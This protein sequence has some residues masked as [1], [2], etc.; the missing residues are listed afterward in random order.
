MTIISAKAKKKK[1][2]CREEATKALKVITLFMM[3]N[4]IR[5]MKKNVK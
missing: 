1:G 5:P 2:N 3:G 4:E